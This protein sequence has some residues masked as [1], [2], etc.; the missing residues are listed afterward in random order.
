MQVHRTV[1]LHT[2]GIGGRIE[3]RA[4]EQVVSPP[5]LWRHRQFALDDGDD[6]CRMHRQIGMPCQDTC[7]RTAAVIPNFE[8]RIVEAGEQSVEA[9]LNGHC[10]QDA[11]Q[12]SANHEVGVRAHH[13]V[14]QHAQVIRGELL[15]RGARRPEDVVPRE[16]VDRLRHMNTLEFRRAFQCGPSRAPR[17]GSADRPAWRSAGRAV[18]DQVS[19]T[20]GLELM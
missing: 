16:Q 7:H 2:S 5:A 6:P 8:A 1:F 18:V 10:P 13:R 4:I 19:G 11:W 3:L 12:S 17:R 14:D 15:E 9:P 20:R